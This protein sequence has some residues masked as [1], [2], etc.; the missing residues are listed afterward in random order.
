VPLLVVGRLSLLKVRLMTGRYAHD[1]RNETIEIDN[2]EPEACRA[3]VCYSHRAV[4]SH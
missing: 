3:I 4:L 2:Q 1:C